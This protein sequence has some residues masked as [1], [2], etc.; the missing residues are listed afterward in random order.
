MVIKKSGD[1]ENKLNDNENKLGD[2]K[3]ESDNYK[4]KSGKIELM[5]I[6]PGLTNDISLRTKREEDSL[7]PRFGLL[8]FMRK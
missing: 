5:P 4:S 2:N 6:L 8:C 1:N 3:S 7:R